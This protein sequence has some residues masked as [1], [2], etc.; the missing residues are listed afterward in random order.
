MVGPISLNDPKYGRWG[1]KEVGATPDAGFSKPNRDLET[2]KQ[3]GA[4]V[5][6]PNSWSYPVPINQRTIEQGMSERPHYRLQGELWHST[7]LSLPAIHKRQESLRT[8]ALCANSPPGCSRCS[9]HQSDGTRSRTALT[10]EERTSFPLSDL[11]ELSSK[12]E[13]WMR[14][15]QPS[16]FI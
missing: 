3:P 4:V 15:T 8:R 6:S 10:Y 12:K 16:G 1:G 2:E 14:V 5:W 7:Q 11:S 9:S 13:Q